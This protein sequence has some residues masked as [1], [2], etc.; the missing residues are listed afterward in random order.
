MP[1]QSR[2]FEVTMQVVAPAGAR[3]TE[4]KIEECITAMIDEAGERQIDLDIT[5]IT[6]RAV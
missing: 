4:E 2:T 6:A 1:K 3:V 5:G